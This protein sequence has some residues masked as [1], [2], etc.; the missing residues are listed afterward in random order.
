MERYG[1]DK[2]DT[3]FG[4]ELKSLNDVVKDTEFKV[5]ADALANGGDVRGI[6]IDGGSPKFSR[7]DIDKLTDQTKHYGRERRRMA[8][9]GRR[10]DQILRQQIFQPGAAG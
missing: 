10:G 5:F 1:S 3:R 7:K 2:P 8:P 6:C 9:R 4:F